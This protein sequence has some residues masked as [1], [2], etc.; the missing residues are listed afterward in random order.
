[1]ADSLFHSSQKRLKIIDTFEECK[2]FAKLI[3]SLNK[4]SE[5][6]EIRQEYEEN[7][8]KGCYIFNKD[9][10]GFGIYFN[11]HEY[12]RSGKNARNVC[13]FDT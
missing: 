12:G 1:M 2:K 11:T 10:R 4:L 8:P 9:D 6:V 7:Y 13:K 5:A 3:E